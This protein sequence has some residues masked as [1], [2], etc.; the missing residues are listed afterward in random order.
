MKVK[1]VKERKAMFK[2]WFMGTCRMIDGCPYYRMARSLAKN[3][4]TGQIVEIS[5]LAGEEEK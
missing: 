5:T 3:M 1:V 4:R 2:D